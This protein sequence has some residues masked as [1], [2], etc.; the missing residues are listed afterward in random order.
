[1]SRL[2]GKG[3]RETQFRRL[4]VEGVV[5]GLGGR[6]NYDERRLAYRSGA[7]QAI[8]DPVADFVRV[9]NAHG[10][11]LTLEGLALEMHCH[12]K[13]LTNYMQLGLLPPIRRSTWRD[14][15]RWGGLYYAILD[16]YRRLRPLE[17]E[18]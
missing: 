17:R 2:T 18:N 16:H 11:R 6:A 15:Q 13:T 7:P 8:E 10:G 1:M 5:D 4:T 14:R 12:K 9:Y 3:A